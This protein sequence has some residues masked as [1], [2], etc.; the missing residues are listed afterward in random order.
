MV[1][2]RHGRSMVRVGFHGRVGL[3]T[4]LLASACS[5]G[6]TNRSTTGSNPSDA[7]STSDTG[8]TLDGGARDS[9][10]ATND[11][12]APPAV[13]VTVSP[14]SVAVSTNAE[15]TYTCTVTG[16]SNTACAWKVSEAGGGSV[17]PATGSTA[18]YSAPATSGTYHV[19]A[20]AVASPMA[21][22]TATVTVAQPVPGSC[23]DL[24]AAGTWQNITPPSLDMSEWC[25]PY[26]GD[27][28]NPGTTSNGLIGTYGT[29][30]FVLD[31]NNPGTVFLGTSSLGLW[32]STDCGSTWAHVDTGANA[33]A[34]D[35]GRNWTMVMDPTD[36]SVLYTVSGY[37]Q[38]GVFKST[39]AGVSWTQILT[40]NIL[41]ATGAAPCEA[42]VDPQVCGGGG[43]FVEKITMDP[44]DNQHLLVGFHSD[45]AG[46]TPLPGATVDSAGGW[47]CLAESMD[48]G[49]TWTLTTSA[50]PWSGL[51]GP[52]QT[53]IDDKTWFYATN[54]CS[55][56]WR[57]TTGGVSPD[58]TSSGWTE[59]Y[60]GCVNGSVY[61]A[62]NGVFYAGGDNILWSTDGVTWTSIA[63]SPSA[64]SL[65]GSTPMVDDGQTFYLGGGNGYYSAPLGSGALALTMIASTPLTSVPATG[66]EAPA[67]YLD[68]DTTHHVLYTSNLDGGFW[69]Y[70]TP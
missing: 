42:G 40:Q 62:S 54:S 33:S 43:A 11:T 49:Q 58:G 37:D 22:D 32:K 64:T 14:K 28:P 41:D 8:G 4:V 9:A 52:G 46:T 7:G 60:S 21:S 12:G 48:S 2:T 63:N 16:S 10:S 18:V 57:T 29:N 17:A 23:S 13:T 61:K 56:L 51:D 26:G 27:C 30:D 36:S 3:A 45:C 70:V 47:G 68:L 44:T 5:S 53:M 65:N 50:I 31:R 35:G 38:G 20:S 24:P 67:A 6:G 34:I 15:Q 1:E 55:G 39:D 69:R 25:A 59:V 66:E 19:V